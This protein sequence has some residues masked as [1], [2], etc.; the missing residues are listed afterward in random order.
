MF[1]SMVDKSYGMH[2]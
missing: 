2:L 1:A